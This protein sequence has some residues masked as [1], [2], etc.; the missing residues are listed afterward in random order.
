MLLELKWGN[1][2][3]SFCFPEKEEGSC[4]AHPVALTIPWAVAPRGLGAR[5]PEMD[6]Q[7]PE[8]VHVFVYRLPSPLEL[9]SRE[10]GP[11]SLI[12]AVTLC[13]APGS[14]YSLLS[15]HSMS[16]RITP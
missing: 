13:L 9:S 7:L 2:C 1:K 6:M 5:E 14:T 10:R 12:P 8:I 3:A 15:E 16:E 4:P 11:A